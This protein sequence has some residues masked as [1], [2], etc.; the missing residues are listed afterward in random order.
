M[1]SFLKRYSNLYQLINS[2][3][4]QWSVTGYMYIKRSLDSWSEYCKK[5][6]FGINKIIMLSI[7]FNWPSFAYINCWSWLLHNLYLL[8]FSHPIATVIVKRNIKYDKIYQY[9]QMNHGLH[10]IMLYMLYLCTLGPFVWKRVKLYITV[11]M[12]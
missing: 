4:N 11:P 5:H 1:I 9:M 7:F 2:L 6:E 3:G 12:I 8:F 10:L